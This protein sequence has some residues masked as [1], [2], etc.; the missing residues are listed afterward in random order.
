LTVHAECPMH[1]EDFPMD[2]HSCPLKFGSYAYTTTEVTYTWTKNASNSVVVEGESSR[3]NQY[4]LLG[5]T[6]G[7]ETIKSSTVFILLWT[8]LSNTA[9]NTYIYF[10]PPI[11]PPHPFLLALDVFML[12]PGVPLFARCHLAVQ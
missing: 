4:D 9:R 3:L 5:Q 6:V 12:W 1:L 7:N 8:Q 11:S 2:F 10:S